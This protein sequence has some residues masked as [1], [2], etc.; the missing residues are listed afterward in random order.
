MLAD[1]TTLPFLSAAFI[2][3]T[4]SL[5]GCGG[6]P[7]STPDGDAPAIVSFHDEGLLG[8]DLTLK[9]VQTSLK[10]IDDICGD[11]WCE[12]DYDFRFRYLY[13]SRDAESCTL[14]LQ[15]GAR[16]TAPTDPRWPWYVCRTTGFFGF[17]SLV[18]TS[19]GGQQRL[20]PTYYEA[21]SACIDGLEQ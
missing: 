17:E 13:C 11:T 4:C 15:M 10:L 8:N 5:A 16:E 19:S 6:T 21:L 2:A 18:T 12:G 1:P 20:T 7:A 3:L 14:A 9:E